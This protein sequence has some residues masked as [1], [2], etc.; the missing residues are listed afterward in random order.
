MGNAWFYIPAASGWVYYLVLTIWAA[1]AQTKRGF[2]WLFMILSISLALN[3]AG[4]ISMR[5]IHI[6]CKISPK[7]ELANSR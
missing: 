2:M 4:C 1:R 5:N 7:I 6:G 3:L